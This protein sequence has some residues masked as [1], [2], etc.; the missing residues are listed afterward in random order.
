MDSRRNSQFWI[1]ETSCPD[2]VLRWLPYPDLPCGGPTLHEP[3]FFRLG[4]SHTTTFCNPLLHVLLQ[5]L[6]PCWVMQ[7]GLTIG[8]IVNG[9]SHELKFYRASFHIVFK[10]T[11]RVQ[12]D[13]LL[14]LGALIT[15][16][17][18]KRKDPCS[19]TVDFRLAGN[20]QPQGQMQQTQFWV[21]LACGPTQF[22]SHLV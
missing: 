11:D 20:V 10:N 12:L 18:T 6:F 3:M 19:V 9:A 4:P 1:V 16:L 14:W 13:Y 2:F 17:D 7:H 8:L 22:S 15:I 21:L 5:T